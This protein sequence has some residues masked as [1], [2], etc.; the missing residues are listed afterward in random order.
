MKRVQTLLVLLLALTAP[1]SLHAE[2][3]NKD[4]YAFD[5]THQRDIFNNL[6]AGLRCPKCQNQN[7]AD[8]NSEIAKTMR[9]VIAEEILQGQN[10]EEIKQLMV[11]RYGNFV[12]YE[13]PK[14][15][16]TAIL[17]LGPPILFTL[18][19]VV[20]FAVLRGRS[21]RIAEAGK[22][23]NKADRQATQQHDDSDLSGERSE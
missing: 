1:I 20:F 14:Q 5:S 10:E 13:P 21:Q 15:K 7:L 6:N 17:W 4:L 19:L 16:E 23:Q 18:L 2:P 11:D 3:E 8:S 12:L 9:D 22:G